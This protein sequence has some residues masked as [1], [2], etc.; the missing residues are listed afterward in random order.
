MRRS[1]DWRL[2]PHIVDLVLY[3]YTTSNN[4]MSMRLLTLCITAACAAAY[5]PS[6]SRR[7]TLQTF[8]AGLVVASPVVTAANALDACNPKANNCVFVTWTPPP[9]TSKKNAIKDLRS[10][11]EAYPQEGQAVRYYMMW[12]CIPNYLLLVS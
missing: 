6:L 12:L 3:N 4:V 7:Q 5:T 2:T 8:A 11:I 1:D 9:A 10:V